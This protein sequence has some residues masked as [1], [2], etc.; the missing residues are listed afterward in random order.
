MDAGKEETPRT[1]TH[2][3]HD[4]RSVNARNIPENRKLER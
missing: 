3:K 4:T 2:S 1:T